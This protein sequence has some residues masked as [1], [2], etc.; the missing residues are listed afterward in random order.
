MKKFENRKLSEASADEVRAYA[1]QFLGIPVEDVTDKEILA[2]VRAAIEGDTIFVEL[3]DEQPTDQTGSPPPRPEG[4]TPEGGGLVGSLG[5]DDPKVQLTIHADERDGVV[6]TRHKE[7][8]VNGVVWLL[9][10]GQ[11][12]TVP[13][14]VFEALNNAER[15]NITHDKDG[16][17]IFQ[18]AKNTPF[19]VERMPPQHEID[20]WLAKYGQVALP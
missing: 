9:A 14:R 17:A 6:N 3:K 10:R 13:Y 1:Q 2:K 11:S 20:A 8:G 4:H 18:K 19:S 15:D 16:T 7:V 5:R 12:I